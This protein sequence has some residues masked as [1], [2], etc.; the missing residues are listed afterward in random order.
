MDIMGVDEAGRGPVLGPMVIGGIIIPESK[1]KILERM[2]VKDSKKITPKRRLILA[3]KLTKM[4]EH[5]MVI[6]SAQEIDIIY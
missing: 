2:G 1:N 5:D 3:R 4:F 6:I